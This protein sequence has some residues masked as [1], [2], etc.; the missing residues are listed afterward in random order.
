MKSWRI[1]NRLSSLAL[2][3]VAVALIGVA[4]QQ[5]KDSVKVPNGL[6]LSE[7]SGYEDWQSVA[8]IRLMLKG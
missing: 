1:R 4:A 8:P 5:N 3:A 7:F 2:L 6:A